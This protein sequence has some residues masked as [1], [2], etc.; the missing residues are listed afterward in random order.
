MKRIPTRRSLLAAAGGIATVN[1]VGMPSR[2]ADP[3]PNKAI[4][5]LVPFGPGGA[6]DMLARLLAPIVSEKLGQPVVVE[7][8]AGATGTVTMAA[9]AAAP[10]D[11]YTVMFT[12]SSYATVNLLMRNLSFTLE[13]FTPLSRLTLG[14]T[15]MV[16]PSQLG[17][18]TFAEFIAAAKANPGKWSYGTTGIGTSLNLGGET[19]KMDAGIDLTHVPY[20]STP[21]ILADLLEARIQMSIFSV[22]DVQPHMQSGRL[23]GLALSHYER[24]PDFPDL[25]TFKELGYPNVR[26]STDFGVAIRAGTPAPIRARLE[27]AYRTAVQRPEVKERL[28]NIGMIVVGTSSAEFSRSVAED[29]AR[30]GEVIRAAS[31]K[32]E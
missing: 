16:V 9:I 12:G 25:P 29:V 10:A 20:R 5:V 30:Y 31:I 22:P 23:L 24:L 21:A 11:G 28:G 7:N 17:V 3:W 18:K 27:E 19:L 32:L 15:I 2:A 4:H 6:M 14:P 26:P 13:S 1:L 8:R